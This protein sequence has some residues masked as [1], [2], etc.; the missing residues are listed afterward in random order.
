MI[1][2]SYTDCREREEHNIQRVV[3]GV[4]LPKMSRATAHR[5]QCCS[6]CTLV[7]EMI[8]VVAVKAFKNGVLY[9]GEDCK[10]EPKN[11]PQILE[12]AFLLVNR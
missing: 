10:R 4:R 6:D 2:S 1:S 7:D 3:L 5:C 8:P 11:D 12:P 9:H